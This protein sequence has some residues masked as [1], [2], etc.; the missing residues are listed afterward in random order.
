MRLVQR[1]LESQWSAIRQVFVTDWGTR[2]RQP[3][4]LLWI[5]HTA[6]PFE[7]HAVRVADRLAGLQ[8][9]HQLGGRNLLS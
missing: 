4:L 8:A 5:L 7:L 3:R 9:Q 2:Q 6:D 1:K